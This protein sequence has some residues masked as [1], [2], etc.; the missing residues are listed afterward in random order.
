MARPCKIDTVNFYR[1][2]RDP[3]RAILLSAGAGDLS[4]GFYLLLEIYASLH[5]QGFRPDNDI[6]GIVLMNNSYAENA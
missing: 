4:Q 2:L 1:K 6:K 3:E 5:A